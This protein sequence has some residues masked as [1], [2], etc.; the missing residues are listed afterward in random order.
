MTNRKFYRYW[1][2]ITHDMSKNKHKTRCMMLMK[3][4]RATN[5]HKKDMI[6]KRICS[7]CKHG[8]Y[9]GD[10][11]GKLPNKFGCFLFGKF[12]RQNDTCEHFALTWND[13]KKEDY[14]SRLSEPKE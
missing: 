4:K 8:D 9:P 3:V 5:R 1:Y 6:K 12:V 10:Y 14:V 2:L 7:Y 13:V 11:T